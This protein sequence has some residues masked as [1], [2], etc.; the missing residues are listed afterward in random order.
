MRLFR[1]F[2]LFVIA[3]LALSQ[4]NILAQAQDAP[5]PPK[6]DTSQISRGMPEGIKGARLD[7]VEAYYGRLAE[8]DMKK[9]IGVVIE[10]QDTPSALVYAA[11]AGKSASQLSAL[12]RDQTR[13]IAAKQTNLMRALKSQGIEA[14]EYFRTQ[15]VFNGIWVQIKAED[16]RK[17]AAMPGVKALHPIV[18]KQLD[19][20]TSVPLLGAPEIWAGLGEFQ[21]DG[22]SIGII[23]TG[24]DYKHAMFGGTNASVFP[25]AKVVGGYDFA[26]DDYDASDPF[27]VPEPDEDPMD[28]NGH[29]SHVAGTTAGYGVLANGDTFVEGPGDTYADLIGLTPED[30]RAKFHIAPGMAPKADLYALRVFGCSGSTNL[31]ELAIEWAMDPNNDNDFS[32]HLDV[33]NMSLGSSYG[34][35]FDTSAMASNNAAMAGIIVVA[36]AGN[37]SDFAY[38]TGAPAVARYAISVANSV[39]SS[40]VVGAF[41]VTNT[42]TPSVLGQHPGTEAAFGPELTVAGVTGNLSTTTPANGCSAISTDLTNKIA[43]IDRGVCSFK[44]KVRNAQNAGAIGVL[45]ANN[46]V[47]FPFMMGDDATITTPIT[48]PSM[49][50]SKAVGDTLKAQLGLGAVEVRLTSEYRN[51]FYDI[52]TNLEDT[53]DSSSSRGPARGGTYLKPDIAAPGN[54]IFSAAVGTGFDGASYSGTSM[55]SPHVAGMMALLREIHPDWS[56]AELKALAMNTAIHEVFSSPAKTSILTPTRIG[57][58]RADALSASESEVIAYFADDPG[59]VSLSFGQVQVVTYQVFSKKLTIANKGTADADYNVSFDERYAPNPGLEFTVLDEDGHPLS[60][61]VTVPAGGE[62]VL[63]VAA[64]VDAANLTH[65]GSDPNLAPYSGLR[66]YFTEGGGYVSLDSTGAAPDLRVPVHIAA[67]PASSMDM[68]ESYIDLPGI[69]WGSFSLTFSGTPVDTTH[70]IS[71]AYIL[72]LMEQ[73]PDDPWSYGP[74]DAADIQYVGLASDYPYW[75]F[76]DSSLYFGI[77]TFGKWDQPSTV[78]FDIYFDTDENGEW[79]YVAYNYY[80]YLYTGNRDL[81]VVYVCDLSNM[82]CDWWWPLNGFQDTSLPTNAFNNNVMVLPVPVSELGLE[83]GVNSDFDFQIFSFSRESEYLVDASWLMSYDL[84]NQSFFTVDTNITEM[85][86]WIDYPGLAEIGYDRNAMIANGSQENP[87]A[88]MFVDFNVMF[89]RD[90][91]GVDISDFRLST[92]GISGAYISGVY[93]EEMSVC[94]VTVYTGSGN[95]T[96]RLDLVD[97]DSIRGASD[98]ARLGGMGLD[99]GSFSWGEHYN[100]LK[101]PTF[102]DV[103]TPYWAWS[104]IERLYANGVTGGCGT[105]PLIY[106]PG[107]NVTRAQMA[108]FLLK[109]M[110]GPSYTPPAAT[111]TVFTDVPASHPFAAWIEELAAEG[112]T[113]G[114]PDG[115]YRPND[116]VTRAQMAVFLL[117]AAYGDT[118]NPPAASGLVFDDVPASNAFAPWIEELSFQGITSGC[119]AGNYCPNNPVT[120]AQMAV[121]LVRMFGLQMP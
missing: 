48:I 1:I 85:P 109:S 20:G 3:A 30:Y 79:D 35:E 82:A 69:D 47:G 63:T 56:V 29:G 78:E 23:D 59:Q 114:F 118:Y 120:R 86:A 71:A 115:T 83:E 113:A 84:E 8:M 31:T 32:D 60:N 96:I 94:T 12:T 108:V 73:N 4:V 91:T 53:I 54:T 111:G 77:S 97:N 33:I 45:I 6:F 87:S 44:T 66:Y 106:C 75:A 49:M 88:D 99:N 51:M 67:R 37:S 10:L 95:G 102:A 43:L 90:V 93:C 5:P 11:N 24:I 21:G 70:E 81:F 16:A 13:S 25:T 107:N 9:E 89:S 50:T 119:G 92:S 40:A 27:S 41:E 65:F 72:E 62:V 28:C 105:S 98:S 36:S 22:I 80:D 26:G 68:A 39:D 103:P 64:E 100:I 38:I 116:S 19:H 7:N 42:T 15:K 58:G 2:S 74:T 46:V 61:P 104:W 18:P 17:V 112:I 55:A 121:F 14:K 34:S 101:T 57:A 117:K 110:Y 76:D 52:D